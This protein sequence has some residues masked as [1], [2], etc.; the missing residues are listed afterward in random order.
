MRLYDLNFLEQTD[1]HE[2]FHFNTNYEYN[3]CYHKTWLH[4]FYWSNKFISTR[5][6]DILDQEEDRAGQEVG[7]RGGGRGDEGDASDVWR[8]QTFSCKFY[9]LLRWTTVLRW[10]KV[11]FFL[12]LSNPICCTTVLKL[13]SLRD[14]LCME[15]IYLKKGNVFLWDTHTCNMTKSQNFRQV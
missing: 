9:Y 12:F 2:D 10:K 8:D 5:V 15:I 1:K 4:I 3:S 14:I 7:G 11:C 13:V 6:S